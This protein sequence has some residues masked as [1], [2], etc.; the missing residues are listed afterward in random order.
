MPMEEMDQC[1]VGGRWRAFITAVAES[2]RL[3]VQSVG[4]SGLTTRTCDSTL[5][6]DRRCEAR[7]RL[8]E[9]GNGTRAEQFMP[10]H[11]VRRPGLA[12]RMEIDRQCVAETDGCSRDQQ[13]VE[14]IGTSE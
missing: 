5:P 13:R 14:L 2:G 4:D 1:G 11:P 10:E 9:A 8:V 12:L 6:I 7:A 3:L